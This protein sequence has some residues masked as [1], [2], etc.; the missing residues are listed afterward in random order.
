M[1]FDALHNSGRR[2][3]HKALISELAL[4]L[5]QMLLHLCQLLVQACQLGFLVHQLIHRN[6]DLGVGRDDRHSAVDLKAVGNG[7]LACGGKLDDKRLAVLKGLGE[8]GR[9]KDL[10]LA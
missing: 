4:A 5:R 8:F 10:C 2:L 9:H 6:V 7:N 3:G 1:L